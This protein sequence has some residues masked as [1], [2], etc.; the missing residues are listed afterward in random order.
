MR[1]E[2]INTVVHRWLLEEIDSES[3]VIDATMGNGFDTL[4]L[5]QNA[6]KVYAFD[7]QEEALEHTREK[8]KDC[9]N[10]TLILASHAKMDCYVKE[11]VDAVIFNL[12]YLPKGDESITTRWES[13]FVAIKKALALL[14]EGKCLFLV[15]YIG[16]SEG[17]REHSEFLKILPE[18]K[19]A[20]VERS[21]TYED[22]HDAPVLY[23]IRK[24]LDQIA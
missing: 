5:A 24:V 12:G 23:Q 9:S 22:R 18:L 3:V 8:V 7:I 11:A 14:K 1:P 10:V 19:N 4:F 6:Q 17:A 2:N 20:R 21:Y 16:H 15:F 13:T